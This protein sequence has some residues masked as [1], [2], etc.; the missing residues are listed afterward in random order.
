M[1]FGVNVGPV[2]VSTK[3][4][5]VG[6]SLGP[7]SGSVKVAGRSGRSRRSSQGRNAKG[8]YTS[9]RTEPLGP[10]G[11]LFVLLVMPLM[12]P[13]GWVILVATWIAVANPVPDSPGVRAMAIGAA[14]LYWGIGLLA[15]LAA[16]PEHKR[17]K[18]AKAQQRTARSTSA[19]TAA[20]R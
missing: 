9:K 11:R 5:R 8:R 2:R 1:G 15:I 19:T 12:P 7:V 3:S 13:A 17:R 14:A 18:A 20:R 4:V 6:G 10:W 16:I